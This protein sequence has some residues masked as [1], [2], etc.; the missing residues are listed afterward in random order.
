GSIDLYAPN[1][2]LV[3]GGAIRT[4]GGG[5][6]NVKTDYGDVNSGVNL[7]GYL[8]G[9]TAAPYYRVNAAN[10]GGISTAAGGDVTISA[11]GDVISY[12]PTQTDYNNNNSLYDAGTGAFGPQ[13]GNVT[14]TAGG[15]IFGHY[16]LGNG[17]GTI[18]AGGDI[19]VPLLGTLSKGFALSLISGSWNVFAPNGNI[20]VQD[21]RNPNG[22]FNDRTSSAGYHYFDYNPASSVLFQAGNS[23]EI[24][25]AGAPHT[26]PSANTTPLP[27]LFAPSLKMIAGA[28]GVVL[29]TSVTLLPSPLGDLNIATLDGGDFKGVADFTGVTPTLQMSDSA[30]HSWKGPNSF[31][32]S[33][34]ASSPP[35]LNNPNPVEITVS[36]N[37]ETVDLY[38]TKATHLTVL[39]DLLNS[40]FVGENLHPQDE[41]FLNVSGKIYNTPG[42][43]F[44]HLDSALVSADPGHAQEWDSVFRLAVDS[45]V[46]NVDA[47]TLADINQYLSSHRLFSDIPGF[48]YDPSTLRLGFRGPMDQSILSAI[49]GPLTV[50]VVDAQGKP[51]IGADG[52]FETTS[53]T[54]APGSKIR[55]LYQSTQSIPR[56]APPGYQ[57]GGPG[58]FNIAAASMDLGNTLGVLSWGIGGP[59]GDNRRYASLAGQVASGAGIDIELTGDLTMLTSTIASM[60]GG[61]V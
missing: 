23:I 56:E 14:I 55:E 20:F 25:G 59:L 52:H 60:Y 10:L 18:T 47:R 48:V 19:G 5:S 33:D 21:V 6:I 46:A 38:T 12:T 29:D 3:N 11:G 32:T 58:Q 30:S 13:P 57:I 7:N 17:V 26:F 2:V 1:E 61:N 40:G 49:S 50:L 28:G 44:V 53:Y 41:T 9:Q 42:Y 24:T 22:I 43:M 16:V 8:F 54:F 45:T 35:E 27:F 4:V 36:G 39:G 15:D 37:M 51:I 31:N 34:H